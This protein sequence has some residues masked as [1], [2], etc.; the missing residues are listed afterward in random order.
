MSK[1]GVVG[2]VSLF[3]IAGFLLVDGGPTDCPNVSCLQ[4]CHSERQV[5]STVR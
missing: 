4:V 1:E 5:D 3:V 2:L